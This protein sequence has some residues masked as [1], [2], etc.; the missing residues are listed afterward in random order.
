MTWTRKLKSW[1]K[2]YWPLAI[3]YTVISWTIKLWAFNQG[4]SWFQDNDFQSRWLFLAGLIIVWLASLAH[5]EAVDRRILLF[6]L[7]IL[8]AAS[9]FL[10]YLCGPDFAW[11]VS[12]FIGL[13]L[14]LS[15]WYFFLTFG[16]ILTMLLYVAVI[17]TGSLWAILYNDIPIA[18]QMMFHAFFFCLLSFLL[19]NIYVLFSKRQPRSRDI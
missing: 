3:L 10:A 16:I 9:S 7:F 6:G 11:L 14:G 4:R 17:L 19:K 18:H 2:R 12:S 1:I 5:K 8:T 15:V 13:V